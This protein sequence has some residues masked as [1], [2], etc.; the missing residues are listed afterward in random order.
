MRVRSRQ[1]PFSPM[2]AV[3]GIAGIFLGLIVGYILGSGQ[4]Q[5]P[6]NAAAAVA[7][8]AA[9]AAPAPGLANEQELQAYRNVLAGD[10]KNLTANVDLANRL[11]DAGRYAEAIP[12]YQQAVKVDPKNASVST[13]LGTA[14][15]Y[16]GRPDEALAQLDASLRIDPTH[17]QTLFNI[18]IIRREAKNDNKGAVAAWEQLLKV[19]PGYPE[20]ERVRTL[21]AQAKQQGA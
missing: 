8:T 14:L 19:A 7:S 2:N 18:G 10:P 6:V 21:I 17:A 16:A 15:Y 12:Y 13:D 5:S 1:S 11:Y 3:T 20:A 4:G 9:Q